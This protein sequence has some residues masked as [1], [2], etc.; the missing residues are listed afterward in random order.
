MEKA[1]K[2]AFKHDDQVVVEAFIEGTELA[3]ASL[4]R[5]EN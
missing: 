3:V 4:K 2:I 5:M 1:L